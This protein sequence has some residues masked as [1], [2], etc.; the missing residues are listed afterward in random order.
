M[1]ER[2]LDLESENL[3]LGSQNCYVN[4]GKLLKVS[5]LPFLIGTLRT[6]LPVLLTLRSC[7]DK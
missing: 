2:T 4:P 7:E 3:G 5:D 1:L 6:I